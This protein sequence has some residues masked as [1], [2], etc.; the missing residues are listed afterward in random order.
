LNS[1]K[2]NDPIKKWTTELN[3]TFSKE[4]I[5]MAKKHMKKYPTS[6]VTKQMQIKTTKI[7][8]LTPI[9]IAMVKNT[10]TNKRWLGC[11]EKGSL[12]HCWWGCKLVQP[13]WKTLQSFDWG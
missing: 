6:L 3:R 10:T 11:G 12:I 9:R 4:K 1:P 13:P 5:Q 8:H 7:F 2:I